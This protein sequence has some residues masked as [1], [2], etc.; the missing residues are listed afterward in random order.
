MA[1]LETPGRAA[2]NVA[3]AERIGSAAAGSALAAYGVFRRD[4]AGA[5][6]ATLG[7]FL[8]YRG[9][10]GRCPCYQTLGI[11]TA[12]GTDGRGVSGDAGIKIE[13]EILISRS[14]IELYQF[15]RRLENLPEIMPHLA[16]VTEDGARSHW[17]VRG[18]A[19]HP[20]EW[21]AEVINDHPGALIA[22]QSLPGAEVHSAGA[23][24][25]ESEEDGNATRLRL[26]L[27][28]LP[29][30]GKAGALVARLFGSAPDQLIESDLA[31]FKEKM[32][33]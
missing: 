17:V 2:P 5:I 26:K 20:I 12:G 32:E 23:V 9:A 21:D 16:S 29:P 4:L 10:M 18:P 6:L 33:T 25:F 30:A 13:K 31:L 22:W 24:H 15:W 7:G 8:I 3:T 11:D 27:E 14:P 1:G 19:G 28:Y